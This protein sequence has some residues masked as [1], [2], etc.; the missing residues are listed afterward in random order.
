MNVKRG[1]T[2]LQLADPRPRPEP[3]LLP[4]GERHAF[5]GA[6]FRVQG[7]GFRVQGSGF[8]VQGAGCRVQGSGFRV[9]GARLLPHGERHAFFVARPVSPEGY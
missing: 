4:H 6:G 2:G 9:Q 1:L 3:R 8:R 7:A 5:Q